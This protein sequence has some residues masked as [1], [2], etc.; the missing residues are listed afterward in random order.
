MHNGTLDVLTSRALKGAEIKTR[1]IWLNA[2]QIHLRRAF[3]TIWPCG[4]WRVFERVL[5]KG[6][7]Q[8][9]QLQAECYRTLSHRRLPFPVGDP[10]LHETVNLFKIDH[11]E[12]RAAF[13]QHFHSHDTEISTGYP[14]N[15]AGVENVAVSIFAP[16]R[17]GRKNRHRPRERRTRRGARTDTPGHSWPESSKT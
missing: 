11:F 8:L 7:L 2:R 4:Y 12:V 9:L 13:A 14:P 1:F 15:G 3:W 5:G 6:H 16:L 10:L 17:H